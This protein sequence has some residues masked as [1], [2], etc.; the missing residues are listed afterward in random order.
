MTEVRFDSEALKEAVS[1][2]TLDA[3]AIVLIALLEAADRA[4]EADIG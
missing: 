4:E 1:I 2:S 3:I